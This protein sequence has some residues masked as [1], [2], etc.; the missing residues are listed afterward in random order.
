MILHAFSLL[1]PFSNNAAGYQPLIIG[2]EL[3]LKS[4]FTMVEVFRDS[5]QIVNKMSQ[6]YDIRK[7]DLL[8]YYN[9]AQSLRQKFDIS[10]ITHIFRGE[11]VRADA[12][13]GLVVS[14]TI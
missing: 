3:A 8:P 5:Q 6:K 11:T 10:H 4:A 9:E 12:R 13:A 1:E 2:L 14:I 7:P